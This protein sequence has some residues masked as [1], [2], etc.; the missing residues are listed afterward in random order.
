MVSKPRKVRIVH[1]GEAKTK[2]NKV[3]FRRGRA[4][5]PKEVVEWEADLRE[6][7]A[8]AMK[9]RPAFDTPVEV[10]VW[11]YRGSKRKCDLGN[12]QKSAMDALNGVVYIDDYLIC[13][14]VMHKLYD[15]QNPRMEIEVT[16][17]KPPK[18]YIEPPLILP[19]ESR[20]KPKKRTRPR[21]KKKK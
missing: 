20:A 16:R 11:M 6:R 14:L 9:G 4:Y 18:N 12:Y 5:I 3:F 1:P 17:W 21:V 19:G 2:S 8:I 15:K 7:A 13:K 10:E